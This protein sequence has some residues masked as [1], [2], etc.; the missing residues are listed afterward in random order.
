MTAAGWV[1]AHWSEGDVI[2]TGWG[3]FFLAFAALV[4][5]R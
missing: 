2:L 3:V 5:A 4:A 1:V